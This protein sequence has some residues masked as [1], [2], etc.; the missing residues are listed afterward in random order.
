MYPPSHAVST[1]TSRYSCFVNWWEQRDLNPPQR[2]S[3]ETAQCLWARSAGCNRSALQL[4][5]NFSK[6]TRLHS[7][8]T[9][10]RDTTKLY[11][12][13]VCC[14]HR[15]QLLACRRA[16]FRRRNFFLR[17]FHRWLPVFFQAR[18]PRFMVN[19][20]PTYLPYMR[21]SGTAHRSMNCV[22]FRAAGLK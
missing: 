6:P 11:Y 10:A 18:E 14:Y 20:L 5:I 7:C 4:V 3:S 16:R 13:P 2:V 9:G 22:S 8:A 12:T 21:A 17:H 19:S 15:H 1:H